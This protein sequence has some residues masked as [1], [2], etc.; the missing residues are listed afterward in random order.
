MATKMKSFYMLLDA[1]YLKYGIVPGEV[2]TVFNDVYYKHTDCSAVKNQLFIQ[3]EYDISK[4][5]SVTASKDEFKDDYWMNSKRT[6]AKINSLI[7]KYNVI[8]LS[9]LRK[10]YFANFWGIKK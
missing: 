4:L 2:T 6:V 3:F 5:K 7:I 8:Y 9:E 1:K 10:M